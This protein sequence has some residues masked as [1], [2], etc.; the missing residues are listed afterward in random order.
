[1]R[2]RTRMASASWVSYHTV[3]VSGPMA[4]CYALDQ[5]AMNR[6]DEYRER[7]QS[8]VDQLNQKIDELKAKAGEA[9]AEAREEIVEHLGDLEGQREKAKERLKDLAEAGEEVWEEV[10]EEAEEL[11]GKVKTGFDRI[12]TRLSGE[13]GD[14]MDRED[15]PEAN[16][17]RDST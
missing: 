6:Q 15:E 1:M 10:A 9:T 17:E 5:R 7:W 3:V 2:G 8:L 16:E 13:P 12:L 14:A 11:F 4:P